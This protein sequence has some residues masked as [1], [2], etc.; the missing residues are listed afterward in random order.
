MFGRITL[1]RE[2]SCVTF[3]ARFLIVI[4]L[5]AAMPCLAEQTQFGPH[6]GFGASTEPAVSYNFRERNNIPISGSSTFRPAPPLQLSGPDAP[7]SQTPPSLN[8]PGMLVGEPLRESPNGRLNLTQQS[9]SYPD[10]LPS[11]SPPVRLSAE[12]ATSTEYFQPS[13]AAFRGDPWTLQ[14]L[15]DGLIYRSYLAGAKESRMGCA[16]VHEHRQGW[17]WDIALGGRMGILRFGT[18]NTDRP[19]GW[20]IDIEGASLPRLDLENRR[21]LTAVDF[22]FGIPLTYGR[23]RYQTK[24]AYYHLSSHLGDEFMVRN[25]TLARRNYSRDV[26]VWGHSLFVTDDVRLY[27]E[28][29]WAFYADDG[30]EPW[31][32]Q[33]GIDYS[34]VRRHCPPG[35]PFFAI[36]GHLREE[37]DFGG[38]VVVQTG[39]QWRGDS[40][41]LFRLGMQYFSGMSDQFEF[42]DQYEDK[43]G[44]GI[45]YD[46]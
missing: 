28:A 18:E 10:M 15:P 27:A 30:A 26:L 29:G 8:A 7:W 46:Y 25:A 14:F 6:P 16:F 44:F 2:Q 38:N 22:R 31:E 13:T 35:A 23:G 9:P 19:D 40:G 36:N 33:F 43:L 24:F 39:W 34:P 21:D 5:A 45:W 11:S 41:H 32:F 3:D 12:P 1:G 4:W 37:V 20:Q 17:I 42:Y